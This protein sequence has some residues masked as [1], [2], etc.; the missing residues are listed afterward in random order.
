MRPRR[1]PEHRADEFAVVTS[2]LVSAAGLRSASA[3]PRCG[4]PN[5]ASP[6][7]DAQEG[8]LRNLGN[9]ADVHPQNRRSPDI[10]QTAKRLC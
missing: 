3:T 4:T 6:R 7:D 2:P 5:E 10:S 9:A 8:L 1:W